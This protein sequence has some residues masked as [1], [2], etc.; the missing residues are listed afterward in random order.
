MT[1]VNHK[2][3]LG[4][5]GRRY[6]TFDFILILTALDRD[7]TTQSAVTWLV[8]PV[9]DSGW[10][11]GS[12]HTPDVKSVTYAPTDHPPAVS[13]S[14]NLATATNLAIDRG[15]MLLA[16]EPIDAN[17]RLK[18]RSYFSSGRQCDSSA[19]TLFVQK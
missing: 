9:I 8:F 6:I 19:A 15:P 16:I 1:F 10:T 3:L 4:Q 14:H 2:F 11:G 17:I 18:L 7:A 13:F 5:A 12:G